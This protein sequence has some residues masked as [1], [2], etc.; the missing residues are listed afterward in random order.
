MTLPNLRFSAEFEPRDTTLAVVYRIHN[1]GQDDVG[2]FNRLQTIALDGGLNF[3]TS[4]VF[5]ELEGDSL[6]LS[7]CALPIPDGL[8]MSSYNAPHASRLAANSTLEERFVLPLP[9]EVR[10]PFR[11]ALL[12]GQVKPAKAASARRIQLRI[13]VFPLSGDC[14]LLA[15]HPA[16][17]EVMVTFP[18][19]VAVERQQILAV[20]CELDEGI[21]V[22][23]YSSFAYR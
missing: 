2:V 10:Q 5:R 23:D 3:L 1:D 7:K 12:D 17:P 20:T 8:R 21:E 14:R 9:L 16:F 18:P 11:R 19:G 15:E 22:L 4:S 13:G 6:L